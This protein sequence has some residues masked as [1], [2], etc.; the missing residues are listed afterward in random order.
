MGRLRMG[1]AGC[2]RRSRAGELLDVAG[3]VHRLHGRDR[4]HTV[5]LAPGQ[6]LDNRLRIGA[7]GVAVADVGAEEFEK[8]QLRALASGGDEG[9][10]GVGGSKGDKPGLGLR[11]K[12]SSSRPKGS[13]AKT[14]GGA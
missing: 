11:R 9:R 13:M 3:D 4:G 5:S 14:V 2:R 7:P 1:C 12:G 6:E 8:A 10:G